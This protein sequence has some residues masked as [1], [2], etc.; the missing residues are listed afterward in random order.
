VKFP[1][2]DE[3]NRCEICNQPASPHEIVTRGS[4]GKRVPWNVI[5]L[6]DDHHTLGATA[7]HRLGRTS[8]AA[9]Y[10]QFAGK[11]EAACAR[12]GRVLR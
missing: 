11:I 5:Y 10:P 9:A 7:F 12:A 2:C 3:V 1:D 8:F 4:G 6:C